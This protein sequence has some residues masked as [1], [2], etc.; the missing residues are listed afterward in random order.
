MKKTIEIFLI[1]V[2][3][4]SAL[5]E[6]I[7]TES[8]NKFNPQRVQLDWTS[9]TNGFVSKELSEYLRGRISRVVFTHGAGTED[10]YDVTLVDSSGVDVLGGQGSNV[11]TNTIQSF[12]PYFTVSYGGQTNFYPFVVNDILTLSVTNCGIEKTGSVILYLE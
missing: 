1:M 3:G 8:R 7:I 9:S 5:A 4:L 6:G 12:M 11:A 2:I 10:A